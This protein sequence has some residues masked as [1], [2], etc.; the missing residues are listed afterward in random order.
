MKTLRDH[1]G[2]T[3]ALNLDG[4]TPP[5]PP[6]LLIITVVTIQLVKVRGTL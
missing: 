3:T 1:S 6:Y 5:T 2:D 4:R